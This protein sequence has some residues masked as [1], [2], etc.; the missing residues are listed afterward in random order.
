MISIDKAENIY[1]GVFQLEGRLVVSICNR[2]LFKELESYIIR[3][4]LVM[5]VNSLHIILNNKSA[6][7][8]DSISVATTMYADRYSRIGKTYIESLVKFWFDVCT[9]NQPIIFYVQSNDKETKAIVHKWRKQFPGKIRLYGTRDNYI[10]LGS[11][12]NQ[13]K[14][15]DH[16]IFFNNYIEASITSA[17]KISFNCNVGIDYIHYRSSIPY[18]IRKK[19][20][21]EEIEKKM[22]EYR[23]KVTDII[24]KYK[25]T[26]LTNFY[27]L[28]EIKTLTCNYEFGLSF[29]YNDVIDDIIANHPLLYKIHTI[30]SGGRELEYKWYGPYSDDHASTYLD[31]IDKYP[32]GTFQGLLIEFSNDDNNKITMEDLVAYCTIEYHINPKQYKDSPLLETIL[33]NLKRKTISPTQACQLI[34]IAFVEEYVPD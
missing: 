26:E 31:L 21:K 10:L 29:D 11:R 23:Q 30:C 18:K 13:E 33:N 32:H 4:K 17:G 19:R 3:S 24:N 27:S 20:R 34:N 22:S 9:K 5:P 12:V 25:I 15:A 8:L 2:S 28:P 1:G 14:S 6:K 7:F 16:M